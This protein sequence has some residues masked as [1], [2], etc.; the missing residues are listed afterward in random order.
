MIAFLGAPENLAF[1]A[2]LVL[3][4]LI[5]AAEAIGLG[6]SAVDLDADA[7]DGDGVLGWLGVGQVPLL[8]LL[9]VFLLAFGL[10]G[11]IGQQLLFD[12]TGGLLSLWF[13][14]PAAAVA[15]L[16][17][18]AL[19]A[20]ALSRVL[21]RDE[22]TAVSLDTLVGRTATIV[23][24]RATAGSPARARVD[25]DH[26]QPHYVMVEPDNPGQCFEQGDPVL[27][28]RREAETFRG[29]SR[30][31]TRLPTLEFR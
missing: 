14:V 25:D 15:A 21:P 24:G 13:A 12:T 6:G 31:D 7:P 1:V 28:V 5:G 17:L 3:M 23:T 26:G 2:A 22:T 10:T 8:V 9:V 4:L 11:L 16:P 27:L 19:G 29:I 30:G 20:R 18:T